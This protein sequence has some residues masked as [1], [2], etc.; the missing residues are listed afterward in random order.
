MVRHPGFQ[1]LLEDKLF[2]RRRPGLLQSTE[3][4]FQMGNEIVVRGAVFHLGWAIVLPVST[5]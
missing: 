3:P 5:Q 2:D 1:V 4:L